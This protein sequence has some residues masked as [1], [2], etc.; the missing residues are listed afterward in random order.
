MADPFLLSALRFQELGDELRRAGRL[1][2]A[3]GAYESAL[4]SHPESAGAWLGLGLC[5]EGEGELLEAGGAYEQAAKFDPT[6]ISAWLGLASMAMA[7][8]DPRLAVEGWM[9]A[10]ALAPQDLRIRNILWQ[11]LNE[12]EV[13]A[14][15]YAGR[16]AE[17]NRRR[18]AGDPLGALEAYRQAQMIEPGLPFAYSRAG[19]LL[20]KAG[21]ILGAEGEF[22]KARALADWVE[23]GIR[24]DPVFFEALP[25][26]PHRFERVQ[27]ANGQGPLALIGCDPVYFKRYGQGLWDS[28]RRFEGERACLHV[29]LVH[30]D[31]ESLKLASQMG[32][33]ISV[34]TPDLA[35]HSRNFVNTYFASARFLALPGLLEAYRRPLLVMD[36]DALVLRPLTPLWQ[37]LQEADMA[38]RR[39]EGVMVDPWNEPQANLVG[40]N[41]TPLGL[42]F[43]E[44]LSSFLAHFVAQGKLFG[45]FDQTALYSV[46]AAHPRLSG[47]RKGA[48]PRNAYGY[49][50]NKGADAPLEYAPDLLVGEVK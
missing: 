33:G 25:A 10:A 18:A 11:G 15:G 7:A 32:L 3:R 19:C 35:G 28:L 45:F 12:I 22:A 44:A 43:A 36:V 24:L 27:P 26:K 14:E 40:I 23:T 49:P 16:V 6:L 21:D 1:A 31:A 29:H 13:Q 34:E 42:A 50:L 17:G 20:A 30:P 5:F 2:E 38:I 37:A 41:P 48:F 4:S 8:N 47:L 46:L 9:K 39:L